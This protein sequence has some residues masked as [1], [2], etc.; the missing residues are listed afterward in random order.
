MPSV[1][2][3]RTFL[4]RNRIK[5]LKS[6][7]KKKKKEYSRFLGEF[8]K[9]P[10]SAFR[11]VF[12]T[13]GHN[14]RI[15]SKGR[16]HVFFTV[17]LNRSAVAVYL[18][19]DER[20]YS[21]WPFMLAGSRIRPRRPS[22]STCCVKCSPACIC[23]FKVRFYLLKYP[24]IAGCIYSLTNLFR[25]CTMIQVVGTFTTDDFVDRIARCSHLLIELWSIFVRAIAPI[26]PSRVNSRRVA[27]D[28]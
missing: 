15:R 16:K 6:Y 10:H 27:S 19:N 21:I 1:I 28:R 22:R 8:S 24:P 4:I 3:S 25:R 2:W 12:T 14:F 26:P 11:V 5:L 23:L 7:P 13:T 20:L 17:T 9:F 18:P